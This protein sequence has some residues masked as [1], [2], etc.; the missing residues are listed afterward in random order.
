V[1]F[2]L[3]SYCFKQFLELKRGG[4]PALW[5]PFFDVFDERGEKWLELLWTKI[6]AK[7]TGGVSATAPQHFSGVAYG[8]SGS[9][10]WAALYE[11]G[12]AAG[13]S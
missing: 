11:M 9:V 4:C 5:A 8:M 7:C 13:L 2:Y 10:N 12:L 3:A 6:K 1:V